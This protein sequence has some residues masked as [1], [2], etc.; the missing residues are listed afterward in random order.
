MSWLQYRLETSATRAADCEDALLSLGAAAVTLEDNADEPLFAQGETE[1]QLWQQTRVSGL[2]PA[3]IDTDALWN[4][5]PEELRQCCSAR[6]EILEDKDWEREWMQHYQPRQFGP[7]LWLCPSWLQAPD[8]QAVNIML[9]PGLAFGTG[10]HPTTAMCIQQ[11]GEQD[12]ANK[13][14]IDFGCGSGILAVTA[15]LLGASTALATDTDSQ[16]LVATRANAERNGIAAERLQVCHPDQLQG[17]ERAELVIA[18]ILAGP[19]CDLAGLLCDQLESGGTMILSGILSE[20]V[21]MLQQH[22]RI[23]LRVAAE[24]EG[25]VALH[26]VAP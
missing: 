16:A 24:S 11:L 18:N 10:T 17:D 2:F 3:D 25:W 14:V 5:L 15:L 8:P 20:Q 23:P 7:R 13:R 26:G 12:L 21:E 22:Y 6:A 1:R 4:A 19:L 9:D